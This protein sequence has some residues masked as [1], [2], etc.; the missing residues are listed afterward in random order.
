MP[1]PFLKWVGGKRALLG[2]LMARLPQQMETYYE[3]FLG[4]GALFFE[5]ARHGRFR[6]AVVSDRNAE[7]CAI[8]EGVRTAPD[9]VCARFE[10]FPQSREFYYEMRAKDWH[11]LEPVDVAARAIFLNRCGFNGLYRLNRHGGFNVPFGRFPHPQ[12]ISIENLRACA[13]VL[14][15]VEIRCCDFESVMNEIKPGDCVYCDPPYWPLSATAH[16]CTYDG[17]HFGPK[18][19]ARLAAAFCSLS[20]RGVAG[21]LSNS[22]TPEVLALYEGHEGLAVDRVCVRRSINCDATKRGAVEE[23]LVRTLL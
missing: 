16:F 11:G 8:W 4:G 12:R 3:P 6:R 2:E 10:S 17:L 9:D 5:L 15:H 22:P 18:E 20:A 1:Y 21:L 13:L 23:I 7:L 19:H 14:Q